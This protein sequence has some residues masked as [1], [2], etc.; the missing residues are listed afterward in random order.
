MPDEFVTRADIER[1]ERRRT[2]PCFNGH[3]FLYVGKSENFRDTNQPCATDSRINV[4]LGVIDHYSCTV[5]DVTTIKRIVTSRDT[6]YVENAPP[7]T[8]WSDFDSN[9]H[10]GNDR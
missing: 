2:D 5:C 4:E 1:E 6:E 7:D 8:F 3:K 10:I 9:N